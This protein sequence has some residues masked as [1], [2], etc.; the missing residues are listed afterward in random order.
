MPCKLLNGDMGLLT[1]QTDI[2]SVAFQAANGLH[3]AVDQRTAQRQKTTGE[4]AN[5]GTK[6]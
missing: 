1:Q 2:F 4:E 5:I 3:A 6:H